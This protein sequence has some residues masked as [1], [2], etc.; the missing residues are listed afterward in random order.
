[1]A[2]QMLIPGV[3]RDLAGGRGTLSIDV[4]ADADAEQVFARVL[5]DYPAL[6]GRIRDE[7]GRIR[8]H[9]NVFLEEENLRSSSLAQVPVPPGSRIHVLPCISGG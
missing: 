7:Q 5:A 6:H 4:P 9:V 3:L 2:V 8:R 1:M